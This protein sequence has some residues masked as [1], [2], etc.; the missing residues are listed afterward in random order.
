MSINYNVCEVPQLNLL[1]SNCF[2]PDLLSKYIS[3]LCLYRKKAEIHF[4]VKGTLRYVN[5]EGLGVIKP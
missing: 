1:F 2:W 4:K 3:R 5:Y